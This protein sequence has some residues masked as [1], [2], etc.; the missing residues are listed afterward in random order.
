MIE[1]TKFQVLYDHYK[2]TFSNIRNYLK[3]RDRLFFSILVVVVFMLFQIFSPKEA[4]AT[5]SQLISSKLGLEGSTNITFVGSVIWFAL[6]GLVVRYFQTVGLIERQYKYIHKV[7]E[8]ISSGYGEKEIFTREGKSY[9]AD[10]PLFSKWTWGLYTIAFPIL[11]LVIVS[12]KLAVEV[13]QADH[14][15]VP[16]IT[17]G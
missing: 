17:S 10:Y 12:I 8:E 4:G 5:I 14:A 1:D 15:S 11:L 2:D 9:L 3:L 16:L 6:L 7:E 13:S